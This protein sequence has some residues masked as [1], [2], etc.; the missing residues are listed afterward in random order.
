MPFQLNSLLVK[1]IVRQ[2]LLE[3]IGK[4]DITT[5]TLFKEHDTGKSCLLAKAG[6]IIAGL[7]VARLVFE[8]LDQGIMW[9]EKCKDGQQVGPGTILAY[10]TGSVR[11][12]LT[13]ERVALNFLQRMSGIATRTAAYV[14]LVEK[15]PVRII[16]TRKTTPG[17]RLLEKYAVRVGGGGNHRLDL[18]SA[19]MIKDNH[20][21]AAGSITNACKILRASIPVTTSIEVE[22]ETIEQV[23][24]ALENNVDIIMLDNMPLEMM[25]QAV[26]LIDKK[27]LV[28]A[29][30]GISMENVVEVARTG[31]D[32]ISIGQLTHSVQVLDISL[33]L[34]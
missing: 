30:G 14:K 20:I 4:G 5:D 6:G 12:I 21:K 3:D 27:A 15:Y 23:K 8:T 13:G 11:T 2:A 18:H 31:V 16:D 34:E 7:D 24:E 10:I 32:L 22:A 26:R 29:S 1:E 28:E 17:L 19:V 25:R 9:E 33:N